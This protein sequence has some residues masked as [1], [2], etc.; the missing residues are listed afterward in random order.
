[1]SAEKQLFHLMA[2]KM[3]E[4]ACETQGFKP[5]DEDVSD[6]FCALCMLID[7]MDHTTSHVETA[8]AALAVASGEFSGDMAYH[9][10]GERGDTFD[11]LLDCMVKDE[12]LERLD[13]D[14]HTVYLRTNY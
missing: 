4:L 6:V 1:M 10:T 12:I 9:C 13:G 3:R 5:D 14:E 8:A 2:E 11:W 7:G